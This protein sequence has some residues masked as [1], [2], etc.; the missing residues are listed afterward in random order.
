MLLEDLIGKGGGLW[1][2]DIYDNISEITA[3]GTFNVPADVTELTIG[4]CGG[5]GGG[6]NFDNGGGGGGSGMT[7]HTLTVTPSESVTVTIGAGGT[8][9]VAGGDSSFGA[10]K[11]AEGGGAGASESVC[12]KG[13]NGGGNGGSGNLADEAVK[14]GQIVVSRAINGVNIMKTIEGGTLRGRSFGGGGA[15]GGFDYEGVGGSDGIS[16]ASDYGAGGACSTSATYNAG[17]D[18]ICVVWY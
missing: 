4:I 2:E 9:G 16:P 8:T 6:H 17:A 13:S 7:Y 1:W 12:G 15:G 11:N 3:S 14:A 18:G 10:Y 5:G